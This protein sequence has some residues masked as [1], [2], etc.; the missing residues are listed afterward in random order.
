ML[1]HTAHVLLPV[2]LAAMLNVNPQ[3][4]AAITSAFYHRDVDAMAAFA[5]HAALGVPTSVDDMVTVAVRFNKAHY[6]QLAM[7]R[8][9][10]PK[11]WFDNGD[12]DDDDC[13]AAHHRIMLL[14]T[15]LNPRTVIN[16]YTALPD[17]SHR[18]TVV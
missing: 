10:P 4:I 17:A 15:L 14:T 11:V 8:F 2:R 6:A 13:A 18:V 16:A 5:R 9:E 3:I 1:N 7:Q 12:D